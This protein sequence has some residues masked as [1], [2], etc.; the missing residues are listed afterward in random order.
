MVHAPGFV[1]VSWP[2]DLLA[3]GVVDKSRVAGDVNRVVGSVGYS[4]RRSIHVL[5]FHQSLALLRHHD[6][7][8]ANKRNADK[9]SEC[10]LVIHLFRFGVKFHFIPDGPKLLQA[11][12]Q[13][14]LCNTIHQTPDMHDHRWKGLVRVF[15]ALFQ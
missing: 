11:L 6:H 8:T 13:V 7:I 10:V 5:I 15:V 9:D 3:G 1:R 4:R 2:G 12:N 14:G